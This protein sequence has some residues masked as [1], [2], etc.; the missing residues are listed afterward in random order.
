MNLKRL[1]NIENRVINSWIDDS[2][3]LFCILKCYLSVYTIDLRAQLWFISP[4]K[5]RAK[6]PQYRLPLHRI[7]DR[8]INC[9][10]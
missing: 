5:H 9:L 10:E 8:E 1:K 6:R 3:S 7:V 4:L 2:K